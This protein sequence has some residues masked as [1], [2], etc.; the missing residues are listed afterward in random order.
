MDSRRARQLYAQHASAMA[1]IDV[2]KPD[3]TRS[4]G[5]AFHI[6]DGVFVTARHVVDGNRIL[7]VKITEPVGVTT[8]E[9]F[10]DVLQIEATE[11]E[12]REYDEKF[13]QTSKIPT[14]FRHYLRP[15]E[16]VEGPC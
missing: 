13:G 3:R 9:Y 16:I 12:I 15:L 2:E 10:R 6:G 11:D 8:R 14:L 7:E 1:Y 5:S 4:I